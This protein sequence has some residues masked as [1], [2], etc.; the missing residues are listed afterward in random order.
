LAFPERIEALIYFSFAPK[1]GML[2]VCW[3]FFMVPARSSPIAECSPMQ[4]RLQICMLLG[5][6]DQASRYSGAPPR[7]PV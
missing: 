7:W 2:R 3:A 1:P 5:L 4:S 6:A